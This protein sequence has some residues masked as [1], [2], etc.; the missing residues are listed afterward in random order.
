MVRSSSLPSGPNPFWSERNR[1]EWALRQARPSDLPMG[2]ETPQN[3]PVPENG[4]DW[5][6]SQ[7]PSPVPLKSGE[8]RTG[9]PRSRSAVERDAVAQGHA[10][11][12]SGDQSVGAYRTPP[13]SWVDKDKSGLVEPGEDSDLGIKTEGAMP[14]MS[15]EQKTEGEFFGTAEPEV[16]TLEGAV[17]EE[18]VKLLV[19]QNQLLQEEVRRL[20][21]RVSD[22]T[23]K[24]WSAVSS[25][26][27]G[28]EGQPSPPPPPPPGS[29]MRMKR[30]ESPLRTTPG[31]TAVPAGPP[32]ED[33]VKYGEVPS[34]PRMYSAEPSY[35]VPVD[36]EYKSGRMGD[37]RYRAL[38]SQVSQLQE[39][40][41]EYAVKSKL[42]SEYWRT[43]VHYEGGLAGPPGWLADHGHELNRVARNGVLDRGVYHG[44][45]AGSGRDGLPGNDR[46]FAAGDQVCHGDR[47]SSGRDGL[48]GSDRAFAGDRVCHQ[49]RA[50]NGRDCEEG[51]RATI[52]VQEI[53]L[54]GVEIKNVMKIVQ[55]QTN[56]ETKEG[57][58]PW[59]VGGKRG[60]DEDGAE[61][62]QLKSIPVVLP[63]LPV[64]HGQDASLA[65]GDWIVQIRPLLGDL[66]PHA[67]QWWDCLMEKTMEQYKKWLCASPLERLAIGPPELVM[68]CHG[69]PRLEMRITSLLLAALPK[70]LKEEL[71]AAR[72]LNVGAVMFK[73]LKTFQPGGL[74]ERSTTLNA[75]VNV[76]SAN[77]PSQAVEKLRLWKRRQ[78][79]AQELQATLPDP[80]IMIRALTQII[81]KLLPTAPQAQF[82]IQAFRMQSRLDVQPTAQNLESYYQFL[83]AEAET[84]AHNPERVEEDKEN[85]QVKALTVASTGGM[86]ERS[87]IPC[88]WWGH[89]DGCR[90][91]R[92][93]DAQLPGKSSRCWL[94]SAKNHRKNECPTRKEDSPSKTPP[95]RGENGEGAKG[96]GKKGNGK[97]KAKSSN[98]S[99]SSL[100]SRPSTTS[101]KPEEDEE[102]PKGEEMK[103]A[104]KTAVSSE[105]T[106]ESRVDG[107]AGELLTE[108]TSL[109]KSLRLQPPQL[110]AYQLKKID[111]VGSKATLLDGGATHCLRKTEN[112]RE[113][114]ESLPVKVQLASGEA[115]MRMHPRKKTLLV[116]QEVQN[117]IPVSKMTELGYEVKW[118]KSGCQVHGPQGE[119][120]EVDMEQ[121]CPVVSV[122]DPKWKRQE[123]NG[124]VVITLD[125]L[126]GGDLLHN[127]SLVGW[128]QEMA[129]TG[130][131]NLWLAGP[132]C[133]SV[134]ALRCKDDGGP[135]Q[136]RGREEGRFGLPGLGPRLQ[137]MVDGDSLLWL[138]MLF[139]MHLSARSGAQ[140]EY[141]VEQPLD[142]QE[143]WSKE[144]PASG[145]PSLMVWEES[146]TVFEELKLDIVRIEQGALGL[147]TPKPTMLATNVS[148]IKAI[149]G[150]RSDSYDPTA[151]NLPLEE[152]IEKSKKLATW[153]PGLKSILFEVIKRVHNKTPPKL[154][155][156]TVK[157]R[158]EVQ[159]WQDHHRAG[160]LPFRKD[161]PTCLLGAGKDRYHKRLGCPTSYT[162][163]MDIMGPFCSGTDQAVNGCRYALVGVYTVP[164]DGKG[165]PLPEGLQMLKTAQ[166]TEE[167][168]EEEEAQIEGSDQAQPW[169]QEDATEE[170]LQ[171]DSPAVVRQQ[172]VLE[173]KWKEFIKDRRSQPVVNVTFGV[174]L[175]SREAGDVIAA[176]ATIFAKVRAMRLPVTRVHT[177]RAREFAGSKFQQWTRDRDIFHTMCAGSEPQANSRAERELGALKAQMRTLLLGSAAPLHYWPLAFRQSVEMRQRSQLRK[178]GILLPQLL[179]FG[180]RA[181]VR[182]K[183][184]H[185]RADPFRWPMMKV[186][187]WGPAG[188][189]AAS[190]QGY[191]VED[192]NGKFLRSTVVMIPSSVAEPQGPVGEPQSNGVAGEALGSGEVLSLETGET[193]EQGQVQPEKEEKGPADPDILSGGEEEDGEDQ[194]PFLGVQ[195]LQ[196]MECGVVLEEVK[197]NKNLRPLAQHDAPKRRY[198]MKAP[199]IASM[200]FPM[201]YKL[202]AEHQEETGAPNSWN[203]GSSPTALER[204]AFERIGVNQHWLLGQWIGEASRLIEDGKGGEEE[205]RLINSVQEERKAL[206]QLLSMSRVCKLQGGGDESGDQE[207]LQTKTVP[208]DEVR[209]N[210]QSW[211][212]AFAEEVKSLTERALKPIGEEEFRALMEGPDEVECLPMKG[213]AT[214][215]AGGRMKGILKVLV[216]TRPETKDAQGPKPR[217]QQER[218]KIEEGSANNVNPLGFDRSGTVTLRKC[219]PAQQGFGDETQS[220]AAPSL[221]MMRANEQVLGDG[222]QLPVRPKRRAQESS[223]A[224]RGRAAH[225]RPLVLGSNEEGEERASGSGEPIA[226][227]EGGRGGAAAAPRRRLTPMPPFQRPEILDETSPPE[228]FDVRH[229]LDASRSAMMLRLLRQVPQEALAQELK[230]VGMTVEDLD[231]EGL[232]QAMV[233]QLS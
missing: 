111:G 123:G 75:L 170:G 52:Y 213:V 17:G 25:G 44:D 100:S 172:Q 42:Q 193:E 169:E 205:V 144:I 132:P 188:D 155:V 10:A 228:N 152:R 127:E 109:L 175:R 153:A 92:S 184:W 117:I 6:G 156:L 59:V 83:L 198:M 162:L 222:D 31:G 137:Q 56:Q 29:P 21:A 167:D 225:G 196:G 219:C 69:R 37:L 20:S 118:M 230:D 130:R 199:P 150:L 1:T 158:Q 90:A 32:P 116:N 24:S 201:V 8:V 200:G 80:S 51:D 67:L 163:S 154:R 129:M 33:G 105:A 216:G 189:M 71:I 177:D 125:I 190:T 151:W 221:R 93:H 160:H 55:E 191:Y 182:R 104:V 54:F 11:R 18:V 7:R 36:V 110:R 39:A 38:E 23:V 202:E 61:E 186:R 212:P 35:Y 62:E 135:V 94:C 126:H 210:V 48:P 30:L 224:A 215:K 108:V 128:I 5:G 89:E 107:G 227:A 103:P 15:A 74:A 76:E 131:V 141:L 168:W 84:L 70:G 96:G 79:R 43:P 2:V 45:R 113:W 26:S 34:F 194:R 28:G 19:E 166:R 226:T 22:S 114:E 176:T 203:G 164:I 60:R 46:A 99:S 115:S 27:W 220:A 159:A 140:S 206:E 65:A 174:P 120:L 178:L 58:E 50:G 102:K 192:E 9:R 78:L 13:S 101:A 134:S 208:M 63:L 85:P 148:E 68:Y 124:V 185:H 214:I 121:G 88:K 77:T 142:P 143:W 81:E 82:R 218:N 41:K 4:S 211:T 87:T 183:E 97:G 145:L 98:G 12:A 53:G 157:E 207:V 232:V 86:K 209:R 161:C 66:A 136:L 14:P 204:E 122:E 223:A 3:L 197:D 231:K 139:W 187:L 179:P 16:K 147:A 180:A 57:M 91:G 146:R 138:R 229:R 47:A 165:D 95:V 217:P 64:P 181:V 173:A 72:Q 195:E 119:R 40:L 49:G 106:G 73:V 112:E 149:D 133:R 171:D 233:Q